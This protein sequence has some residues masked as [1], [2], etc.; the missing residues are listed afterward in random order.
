[1]WY[2]LTMTIQLNKELAL[3]LKAAGSDG[4]EVI[5]PDSNRVY[6]IVDEELHRRARRALRAEE[7]RDAIAEGISQMEAGQ[8]RPAE[9][10]FEDLRN[11]LGFPA[12]S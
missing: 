9:A 12:E 11:E 1:M 8:G 10:V 7:D 4:L 5:D 6:V 3:A 2:I